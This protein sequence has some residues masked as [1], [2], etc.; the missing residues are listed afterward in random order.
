MK[1]IARVREDYINRFRDLQRKRMKSH[2]DFVLIALLMAYMVDFIE[3][4]NTSKYLLLAPFFMKIKNID[5]AK[6]VVKSVDEALDGQ[7]KLA[8]HIKTFQKTNE[9]T[10][11]SLKHIIPQIEPKIKL[12]GETR[13]FVD[14]QNEAKFASESNKSNL[15]INGSILNKK[16][17]QWNTQRDSRV[18][19]TTF[20][21][22]VD[23]Q[24]VP[25]NDFFEVA[26]FRGRYPVDEE[27]PPFD[28]FGCR[29]YL[30]FFD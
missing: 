6:A 5:N 22:G 17:K 30:T 9:N 3:T 24:I 14:L 27:L 18:R 29:C 20:H 26:P 16:M 11:V 13:R 15:L 23:R 7:G 10:L 4:N 19:K 25:I 8:E 12:K 21:N 1:T 28:R 2:D